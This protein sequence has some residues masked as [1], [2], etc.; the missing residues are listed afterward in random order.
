MKNKR[1]VEF[2][3][4][5]NSISRMDNTIYVV[6]YSQE[7][8]KREELKFLLGYSNVVDIFIDKLKVTDLISWCSINKMAEKFGDVICTLKNDSTDRGCKIFLA[9]NV[10]L[11]DLH[12]NLIEQFSKELEILKIK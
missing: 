7:D 3:E 9:D 12:S 4:V 2:Q 11:T 8:I 5:L 1:I 6:I 10:V